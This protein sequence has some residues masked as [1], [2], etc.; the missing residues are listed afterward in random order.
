MV[1][2]NSEYGVYTENEEA[3]RQIVDSLAFD[4]N[5]AYVAMLNQ[6]IRPVVTKMLQPTLSLPP[7]QRA[8]SLRVTEGPAYIDIV[9][10][11]V[12]QMKGA[13]AG[14]LADSD[15]SGEQPK[16]IGYVQLILTKQHL[17]EQIQEFLNSIVL[18]TS[19]FVLVGV[20]LTLLM[21]RRMTSPIKTLA[22]IAHEISHGN[23]DHHIVM[24][25]NDEIADLAHAFT[26]MQERLRA[27]RTQA[28][29]HH[30][31]LEEKVEQRTLEL[32]LAMEN[33]N[34]M[35]QKAEE[36]SRAKS[37]FLANMSHELRTPMNGVLGMTELLLA[38]DLTKRQNRF[39][40]TVHQSGQP[41][42]RPGSWHW[43][44]LTLTCMPPLK[45]PSTC[46]RSGRSGR[47]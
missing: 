29:S 35:A 46:L 5:I 47:A 9:V 3:L 38:T 33:A 42:S 36:A 26:H 43:S 22:S 40:S 10:P 23:F 1:A 19:V 30:R 15:K 25:V 41:R 13:P 14:P 18:C 37:Q 45:R 27:Y 21:T 7:F 31:T 6:D 4:E 16:T 24:K 8:R 32:R 20:A 39:A 44:R 17:R 28:E 2:Q 11:V 34:Q 12:S